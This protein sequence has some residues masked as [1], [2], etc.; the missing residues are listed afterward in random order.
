MIY[1]KDYGNLN[2]II[3]CQEEPEFH[4]QLEQFMGKVIM[5]FVYGMSVPFTGLLFE[6]SSEYVTLV[7]TPPEPERVGGK[8]YLLK[9][10]I[11]AFTVSYE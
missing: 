2:E 3:R 8:T 11:T 10:H 1:I 5:V 9:K 7:T 6:I 4:Q